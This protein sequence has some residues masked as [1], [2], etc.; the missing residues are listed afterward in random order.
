M[1]TTPPLRFN[2]SPAYMLHAVVMMLN[3]YADNVLQATYGVSYSQF[4]VLLVIGKCTNPSQKMLACRLGVTA[5]AI[6][7]Q[8][9]LLCDA[10]LISRRQHPQ[11]RRE[12]VL[13]LT[14]AGQRVADDA[15]TVLG[16]HFNA[17]MSGISSSDMDA[18]LRV[19]TQMHADLLRGRSSI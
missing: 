9:D 2:E 18:F 8:I 1:S 3:R 13:G 11:N 19:L 6:S 14:V 5:A 10:D 17:L 4:L 15:K 16:E 12:Y 7:R